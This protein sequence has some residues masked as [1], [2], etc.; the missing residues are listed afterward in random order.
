MIKYVITAQFTLVDGTLLKTETLLGKGND[1][2]EALNDASKQCDKIAT[3]MTKD[4]GDL[5]T[6]VYTGKETKDDKQI[7]GDN[8]ITEGPMSEFEA[9]ERILE[10]VEEF[11]DIKYFEIKE[12]K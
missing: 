12:V 1:Q 10:L 3:Q 9:N 4:T 2:D 5:V 8:G 11:P 6:Y 7:V